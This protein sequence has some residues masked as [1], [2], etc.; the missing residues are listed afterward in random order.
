MQACEC[1]VQE[2]EA[3]EYKG[4]NGNQIVLASADGNQPE[5]MRAPV[6]QGWQR[7]RMEH[8]LGRGSLAW[9]CRKE[10]NQH[11]CK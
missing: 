6:K 11:G 3:S 5:K 2:H 7:I 8:R 10:G 9:G 1:L 4:R